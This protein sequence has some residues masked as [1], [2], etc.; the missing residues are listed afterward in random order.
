MVLFCLRKK[1]HKIGDI[2]LLYQ[3]PFYHM[4]CVLSIK[5]GFLTKINYSSN[6]KSQQQCSVLNSWI[7]TSFNAI[8]SYE[9]IF[10]H[11]HFDNELSSIFIY[12]YKMVKKKK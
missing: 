5:S 6:P 8:S 12:F 11:I 1:N 9:I 7:N 3:Y 4:E 2:H 10:F